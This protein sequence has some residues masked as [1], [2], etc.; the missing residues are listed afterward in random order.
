MCGGI[1]SYVETLNTGRLRAIAMSVYASGAIP[2]EEAISWIAGLPERPVH[3][4]RRL[5]P[6]QY[7]RDP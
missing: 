4:L 2:A 6:G 3:R 1:D 5:E 7:R